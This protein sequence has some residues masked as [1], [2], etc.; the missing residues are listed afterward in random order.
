MRLLCNIPSKVDASDS[1]WS[2]SS[3]CSERLSGLSTVD[4]SVWPIDPSARP[5]RRSAS[6]MHRLASPA[7]ACALVESSR[8]LN[9]SLTHPAC[10]ASSSSLCA[11]EAGSINLPWSAARK[12]YFARKVTWKQG[13]SRW[14]VRTRNLLPLPIARDKAEN[15]EHW[16]WD[17]VNFFV[18]R[19]MFM[20]YRGGG[21]G[22][23]S[24]RKAM[25]CLVDDHITLNKQ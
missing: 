8:R 23:M 18:D 6:S 19:D 4:T 14:Y 2:P 10:S 5:L 24:I 9:E 11:S 20:R 17:Y 12:T 21:V 1:Q 3:M 16:D 25:R 22:H 13:I 7:L 15:N